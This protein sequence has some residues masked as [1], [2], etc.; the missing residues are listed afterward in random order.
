MHKALF[1]GLMTLGVLAIGEGLAWTFFALAGASFHLPDPERYIATDAQIAKARPSYEPDLGW[2]VPYDTTA[3]ERPRGFDYGHPLISIYGDS[4]VHGDEVA[5][6]E[7]W[8]EALAGSLSADVF[9]FGSSAYGMDQA[10]L[11]FERDFARRPTDIVIFGFISYDVER[12]VS[13]YWKFLY[14]EADLVLTKP[15]FRLQDGELAVVPNPVRSPGELSRLKDPDFIRELGV[16]DFWFDRNRLGETRFPHFGRFLRRG[17]WDVALRFGRPVDA[18]TL[19]EPRA[20]AKAILTRFDRGCRQR[21]ARP[22]IVHLP[23][24]WELI[25]FSEHGELPPSLEVFEALCSRQK[26]R[27]LSLVE[28]LGSR[29]TAEIARLFTAGVEGGHYNPVGNREI[30]DLVGREI[31]QMLRT[32]FS[33][34]SH[35]GAYPSR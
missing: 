29:P 25:A 1:A 23:V 22:L 28:D 18:W 4:F 21:G 11:R 17:F 35:Q 5:H 12:N 16:E 27:C 30:G 14:P 19:E 8:A 32:D 31:R 13:V 33:P 6:G 24:V 20:L 10:L 9:N 26:L 3:G 15:R 34:G 7:T 2:Q